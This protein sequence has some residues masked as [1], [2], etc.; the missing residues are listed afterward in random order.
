MQYQKFKP[1]FK[2]FFIVLHVLGAEK[3]L[4]FFLKNT[5]FTLFTSFTHLY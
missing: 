2:F 4:H 3:L 1:K 5:L